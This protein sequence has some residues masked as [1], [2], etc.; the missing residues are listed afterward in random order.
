MKLWL[1]AEVQHDVSEDLRQAS[2]QI[3]PK[4]NAQLA[5]DYG[6]AIEEWALISILRPRI[7]EGWGEIWRYHRPRRVAEFRLIIDHKEFKG[8]GPQ[9]QR[10][11]LL[12]SILR[13]LDLFGL[14]KVTAF[15]VGRFRR[16]ATAFAEGWIVAGKNEPDQADQS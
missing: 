14:L 2:L 3:E 7:P 13:S 16:E 12:A 15:D 11:M 6:P 9:K 5:A 10:T 4:V 1:S 8:A